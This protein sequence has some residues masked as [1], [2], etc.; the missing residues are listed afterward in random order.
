[1]TPIYD[2]IG[3]SVAAAAGKQDGTLQGKS[4]ADMKGLKM[5]RADS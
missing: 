4:T 1:M 2:G 5:P 3:I